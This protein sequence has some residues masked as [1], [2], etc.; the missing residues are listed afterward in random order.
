MFG[1]IITDPDKIR[2]PRE[3]LCGGDGVVANSRKSCDEL[4]TAFV[5]VRESHDS[6]LQIDGASMGMSGLTRLYLRPAG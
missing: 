1:R 5:G 3:E 2:I 6:L 4:I